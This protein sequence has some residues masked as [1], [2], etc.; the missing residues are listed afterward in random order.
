MHFRKGPL[1]FFKN[2]ASARPSKIL[3]PNR[4]D[5]VMEF[6]VKK[7]GTRFGKNRRLRRYD[8]EE[9]GLMQGVAVLPSGGG[10][11]RL[12]D[13]EG[14]L[15]Q[16]GTVLKGQRSKRSVQHEQVPL[17]AVCSHRTASI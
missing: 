9:G 11:K 14:G 10:V 3:T 13:E 5:G 1:H 2:F 15:M 4:R 17:W 16:G 12:F 8:L 7:L 6:T